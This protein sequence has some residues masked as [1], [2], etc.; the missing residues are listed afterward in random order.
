MIIKNKSNQNPT[1]LLIF[2]P[3]KVGKTSL[4]VQLPNMLLVDTEDGSNFVDCEVFNVIRYSI[5]NNITQGNAIFELSKYL[6]SL[7]T[8]Y[9]YIV[10]DTI[11]GLENIARAMA[12]I[13]YK[14]TT[15]GKNFTGKDVVVELPN[16]AG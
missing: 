5:V 14:S 16:G 3:P 10:I 8:K 15:I 1:K 7:D 11:T 12:T 2:S 13:K 6:K 4:A 9:D